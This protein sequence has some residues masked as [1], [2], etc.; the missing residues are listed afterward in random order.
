MDEQLAPYV[1]SAKRIIVLC[2]AGIS[3]P[4]GIPD[5]RSSDGLYANANGGDPTDV[6]NIQ[7]FRK[8]PNPFY[9]VYRSKFLDKEYQPSEAHR[10]LKALHDSGK[11]LAVFTQ[12][13]DGMEEQVGIPESKVV[14]CH[15]TLKHAICSWCGEKYTRSWL[16]EHLRNH[17]NP[18]CGKCGRF[19][20]PAI[21][22][23]GEPAFCQ[24]DWDEIFEM[25]D[26]MII[27]GTS[28]QVYPFAELAAKT[29]P[30][31]FRVLVN[32][33]PVGM[34][35][36]DKPM[37]F[38]NSSHLTRSKKDIYIPYVFCA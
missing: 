23:Y 31:V 20:K 10:Y 30:G 35:I 2:G 19:V 16:D 5:Y 7:K 3:T 37:V 33:E 14:Q 22:F 24:D 21:I 8:N 34:N 38:T 13:I 32:N 17:T 6:F 28:L 12:N 4:S 27:M 18:K 36:P 15:G 1:K 26:L 11:L 9:D 25:A 29:N